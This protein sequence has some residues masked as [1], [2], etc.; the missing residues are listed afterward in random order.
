[1][2]RAGRMRIV[3]AYPADK[4]AAQVSDIYQSIL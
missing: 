1:M 4:I 2:G 3:E